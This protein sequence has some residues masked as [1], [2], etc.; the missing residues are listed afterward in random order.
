MAWQ[1]KKTIVL[2]ASKLDWKADV[3]DW[4]HSDFAV[5]SGRMQAERSYLRHR[6]PGIT[7]IS[8][9]CVCVQYV[10]KSLTSSGSQL[11]LLYVGRRKLFVPW[12]LLSVCLCHKKSKHFASHLMLQIDYSIPNYAV[13]S[14]KVRLEASGLLCTVLVLY[15]C[16]L[17]NGFFFF[18][19][20]NK[21]LNFMLLQQKEMHFSNDDGTMCSRWDVKKQQQ[22]NNIIS[23][24]VTRISSRLFFFFLSF[25]LLLLK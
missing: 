15:Y 21:F 10:L 7:L 14:T 20:K 24:G 13:R 18:R 1:G 16:H 22:Y 8:G 11:E 12:K 9:A 6:W 3:K 23:L 4:T 25:C 17:I 19:K 5:G 2:Y